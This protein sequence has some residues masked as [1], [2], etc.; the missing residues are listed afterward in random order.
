MPTER[1]KRD[2]HWL[3]ACAFAPVLSLPL[4]WAL[5][6]RQLSSR[7]AGEARAWVRRMVVIALFDTIVAATLVWAAATAVDTGAP[8]PGTPKVGVQL[9]AAFEGPGARVETVWAG[10]PAERAGLRP[11]DVVVEVDGD[12]VDD[13]SHFSETIAA[14]ADGELRV[15]AVSRS[16]TRVEVVV[17]PEVGLQ[18][19]PP[20]R[21]SFEPT[22]RRPCADTWSERRAPSDLISTFGGTL[23]VVLLWLR[24]WR[25]APSA[26]HRWIAVVVPLVTAPVVGI[27]VAHASCL[28]TGGWSMGVLLLGTI[29]QSLA[30]LVFGLIIMRLIRHELAVVVGPR[31]SMGGATK[32]AVFYILTTLVR[33]IIALGVLW[34]LAPDLQVGRDEGI[35]LLIDAIGDPLGRALLVTAVVVVAPVAEEVIFRG[36]LLPGLAQHFRPTTALLL[37]SAI[38]GL[39]HVPSHGIGAVI[40][41]LLGVVF[42]WARLRTGDLRVSIMLHAANNLV[43]TAFA[44]MA[45]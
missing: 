10:S 20:A 16:D 24:A 27:A 32:R 2:F 30:L 8:D 11:G 28:T 35:A 17:A 7:P 5:T 25:K 33:A 4:S 43:V 19:E 39:F 38:F 29:G 42:G 37:S 40:P 9:D 41:G 12:P 21:S 22:S 44:F 26:R 36:V 14:G 45:A 13:W 31:L 18:V 6:L 3:L 1:A 23:L 15:L 34:T